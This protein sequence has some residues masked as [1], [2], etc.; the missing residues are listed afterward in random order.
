VF[1]I[2]WPAV[3][4]SHIQHLQEKELTL[5]DTL[6]AAAVSSSQRAAKLPREGWRPQAGLKN[7]FRDFWETVVAQA[8]DPTR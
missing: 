3:D 8:N 6:R 2:G 5:R 1:G 7:Y 4:I